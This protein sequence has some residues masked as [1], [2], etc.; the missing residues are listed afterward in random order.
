MFLAS[1]SWFKGDLRSKL[2]PYFHGILLLIL[3]RKSLVQNFVAFWS[4]FT[5]LWSYRVLIDK[6]T[7]LDN[8]KKW[9]SRLI[10]AFWFDQI[11]SASYKLLM[12]MKKSCLS[13]K[14]QLSQK[15]SIS[16]KGFFSHRYINKNSDASTGSNNCNELHTKSHHFY[17]CAV[18]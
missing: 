15:N 4:A 11:I 5:N 1:W 7:V 9:L 18:Y 16:W 2:H 13:K 10:Y 3:W 8:S 17:K 14:H 12:V 6:F